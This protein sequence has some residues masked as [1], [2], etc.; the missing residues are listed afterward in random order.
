M[1]LVQTTRQPTQPD[2]ILETYK[3]RVYL[4]CLSGLG[5][6]LLPAAPARAGGHVHGDG[7]VEDVEGERG[8]RQQREQRA[9]IEEAAR[10]AV[11][12][13]APA[14]AAAAVAAARAVPV[15]EGSEHVGHGGA[16]A[17]RLGVAVVARLAV[18][19]SIVSVTSSLTHVRAT[20]DKTHNLLGAG[21][22]NKQTYVYNQKSKVTF[23]RFS[24]LQ[25]KSPE[26][27]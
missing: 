2:Y 10:G 16:E 9:V 17:G 24:I 8:A 11:A 15:A 6:P 21:T 14:A 27:G 1:L 12:A 23:R 3:R 7:G 19:T 4:R 25:Y 26:M 13:A 18:I 5:V 22:D 20:E